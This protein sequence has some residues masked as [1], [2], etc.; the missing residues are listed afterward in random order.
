M[1]GV[2]MEKPDKCQFAN[3]VPPSGAY[4][5]GWDEK[6]CRDPDQIIHCPSRLAYMRIMG[7]IPKD[8]T[9]DDYLKQFDN[10]NNE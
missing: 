9:F 4:C 1:K 3:S 5:S 6:D 10:N 7:H 8:Q 2:K